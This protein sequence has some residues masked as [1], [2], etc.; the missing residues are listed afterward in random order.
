MTKYAALVQDVIKEECAS[1]VL[2]DGSVLEDLDNLA[3]DV[4]YEFL[5]RDDL[6]TI[7]DIQKIFEE[8]GW[9]Y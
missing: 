7:F 5:E 8:R 9:L 6:T 1:L 4:Y 3:Q 2:H